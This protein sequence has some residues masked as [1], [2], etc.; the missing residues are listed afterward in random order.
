VQTGGNVLLMTRN[1]QDFCDT[2]LT[3]YL[4]V[5]WAELNASLGNCVAAYPGLVNIPFTGSQSWND[6]FLV[7]AGAQHTLLFQDTNGFASPRGTG[8]LAQPPGGGSHRADGGNFVL[9]AGR[10]YR[11]DH[12]ALR[13]NV[14]F[15]LE[16]LFDEPYI[17][18]D[19][20]EQQAQNWVQLSP[21]YPNPFTSQT[22]ISFTLS[23]AGPVKLSV[24]DAAGRLVETLASG[25]RLAGPHRV[26]WNGRDSRGN[27]ASSGTYFVRLRAGGETHVRSVVLAR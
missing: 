7:D 15:I 6:V 17:V 22:V 9:V 25:D 18:V 4:D 3:G 23:S 11:M 5:S 1:S 20:P 10:P 12:T 26:V 13:A 21:G 8:V 24:Y 27:S 16:N 19:V 14:E 2:D